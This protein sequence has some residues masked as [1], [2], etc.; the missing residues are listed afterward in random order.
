MLFQFR[1]LFEDT[2]KNN[3]VYM[4]TK[5]VD[6]NTNIFK[7]HCLPAKNLFLQQKPSLRTVFVFKST[8]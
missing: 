7:Y 1:M 2:N 6:K 4:E 5:I 3:G 8:F